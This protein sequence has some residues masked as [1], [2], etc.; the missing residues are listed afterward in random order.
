MK[1][2]LVGEGPELFRIHY[3]HCMKRSIRGV[4]GITK[5]TFP[6]DP[7]VA[8]LTLGFPYSELVDAAEAEA[9]RPEKDR[10]FERVGWQNEF[11]LFEGYPLPL[12]IPPYCH[13]ILER[14]LAYPVTASQ[15]V[16]GALIGLPYKPK[17]GLFDPEPM[18]A[19]FH[20][21]EQ[22]LEARK[23]GESTEEPDYVVHHFPGIAKIEGTHEGTRG[24]GKITFDK[25]PNNPIYLHPARYHNCYGAT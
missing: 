6:D 25:H 22:I 3:Q 2:E 9:L 18:K 17:P 20:Q 23:R 16:T 14:V 8:M 5:M 10:D 1:V 12:D 19:L 15:E 4:P 13:R 24:Q 21:Q 7:W 11:N